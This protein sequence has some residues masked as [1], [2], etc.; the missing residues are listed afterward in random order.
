[1]IDDLNREGYDFMKLFR[2][3]TKADYGLKYEIISIANGNATSIS[4]N[5]GPFSLLQHTPQLVTSNSSSNPSTSA[6]P[7]ALTLSSLNGL[8][9]LIRSDFLYNLNNSNLPNE[10]SSDVKYLWKWFETINRLYEIAIP[11]NPPNTLIR[12][13]PNSRSVLVERYSTR[14]CGLRALL[15]GIFIN[16]TKKLFFILH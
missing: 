9:T 1:M 8:N 2:E 10:I 3:R 5:S 7:L 15:N 6:I 11:L 14:Y 4:S 16:V 13:P 12:L